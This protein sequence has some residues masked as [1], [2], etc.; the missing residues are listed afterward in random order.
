LRAADFFLPVVFF[1]AN[2]GTSFLLRTRSTTP[3]SPSGSTPFRHPDLQ[4]PTATACNKCASERA[5][6][7]Y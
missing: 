4:L 5:F 2:P 7:N 1:A 3:S 6:T